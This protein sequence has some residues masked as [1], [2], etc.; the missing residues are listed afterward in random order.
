MSLQKPRRELPAA[1]PMNRLIAL[2]NAPGVTP[3]PPLQSPGMAMM[4]TVPLVLETAMTR[5]VPSKEKGGYR[6]EKVCS[7][8]DGAAIERVGSPT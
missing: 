4:L 6:E 2:V 3:L 8:K 5:M 7:I 1:L